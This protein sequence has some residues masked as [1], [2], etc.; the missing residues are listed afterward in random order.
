MR[1]S[2][3][4]ASRARGQVAALLGSRRLHRAS[5]ALL[6][7]ELKGAGPGGDDASHVQVPLGVVGGGEGPPAAVRGLRRRRRRTPRVPEAL[8]RPVDRTDVSTGPPFT[9]T[10]KN[11]HSDKSTNHTTRKQKAGCGEA[12]KGVMRGVPD[13]AAPQNPQNSVCRT[14]QS[15]KSAAKTGGKRGTE[16]TPQHA[17]TATRGQLQQHRHN[18]GPFQRHF[19]RFFQNS[20]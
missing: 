7:G 3:A 11:K 13:P 4:A 9:R 20:T 10:F 17:H 16:R 5:A 19:K 2:N 1:R 6:T 8:H 14:F 18:S 12:W 15:S